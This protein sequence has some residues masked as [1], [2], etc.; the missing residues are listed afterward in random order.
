MSSI[1]SVRATAR[2]ESEEQLR[3]LVEQVQEYAIYMLDPMGHVRSWNQGAERIKGYKAEEIL[4]QHFSAFYTPEDVAL[5]KPA[6]QLARAEAE[7]RCEDEGWR[8]RKDGSRF[9]ASVV[10]TALRGPDGRLSGFGKVTRDITERRRE[11]ERRS[12][13]EIAQLASIIESSHHATGATFTVTLPLVSAQ[14]N[15][16][17]RE[18]SGLEQGW[19]RVG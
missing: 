6:L 13:D 19:R 11:A 8:M 5:H 3:L 2:V 15:G 17:A 12:A 10:I 4:G 14:S 9:W 18:L 16:F 7:G 1:S